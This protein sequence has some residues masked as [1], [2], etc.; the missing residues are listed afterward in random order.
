MLS[1]QEI[2]AIAQTIVDRS[3]STAHIDTGALRRSISYT[4]VRGKVTFRELYYGQWND[5]SD[6]KRNAEKLMPYG[7]EWKI[8]YTKFGGDTYEETRT[9]QGRTS[10]RKVLST[11]SR[12]SSNN[13]NALIARARAKKKK[14]D[15]Q[16]E[17]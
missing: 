13:I 14:E 11:I 2:R 3:K 5:N 12:T 6:L 10:Q 4:Y 17:E 15:G 1:E 9:K 16:A 8:I 7:T